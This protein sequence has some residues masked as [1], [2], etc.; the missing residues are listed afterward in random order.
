[1]EGEAP[2][3]SVNFEEPAVVIHRSIGP[4]SRQGSVGIS[5]D[6]SVLW[7]SI[8]CDLGLFPAEGQAFVAL[9]TAML[10]AAGDGASLRS[11]HLPGGLLLLSLTVRPSP[12]SGRGPGDEPL[13]ANG[14]LTLRAPGAASTA[15]RA[16][17]AELGGVGRARADEDER[18]VVCTAVPKGR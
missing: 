10:N 9:L 12:R 14:S 2:D 15:D 6:S 3:S 5:S 7:K 16:S 1:M 18:D 11:S 17:P 4:E 13:Q 8:P